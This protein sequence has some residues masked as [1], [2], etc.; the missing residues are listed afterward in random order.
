VENLIRYVVAFYLSF[1][2]QNPEN[3]IAIQKYVKCT[4]VAYLSL[5][6]KLVR[7]KTSWMIHNS[8]ET[9]YLGLFKK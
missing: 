9:R 7:W 6:C 4:S 3:V 5:I 8:R 1:A 2:S